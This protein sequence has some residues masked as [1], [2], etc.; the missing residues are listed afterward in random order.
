[1]KTNRDALVAIAF[2]LFMTKGFD[3]TSMQDLARASGLSKGAFH[4]YFPRKHD[5]LDACLQRFF[6]DFLP[7]AQR[8]EGEDIAQFALYCAERHADALCGLASE[9]IPLAAFQ[10]FLWAQLR[11]RPD[12]MQAHQVRVLA[13]FEQGF[14][15]RFPGRGRDLARQVLAL[16]EGTG[17]M[18]SV[19]PCSDPEDVTAIFRQ[20]VGKFLAG[21]KG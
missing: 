6:G 9:G 17:V 11:D 7:D 10:A 8:P 3:Q 12:E 18:L 4:H 13:Q 14:E 16:I 1:M 19:V 20:V 5:I 21:L 15:A 2:R